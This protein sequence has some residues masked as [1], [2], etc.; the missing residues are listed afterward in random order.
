MTNGGE[1][2]GLRCET[3]RTCECCVA[4]ELVVTRGALGETESGEG[5]FETKN[6]Y[7]QVL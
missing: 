7:M 5:H 6:S 1:L 2:W 3:R 4:K